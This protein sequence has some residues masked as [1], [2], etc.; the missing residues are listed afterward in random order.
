M[1]PVQD[2][3]I[4]SK[5][6]QTLDIGK[7][8]C[9][10]PPAYEKMIDEYGNLYNEYK[11]LFKHFKK[12]IKLSDL[13]QNELK[14]ARDSQK[15]LNLKLK[16]SNDQL[17]EL[18]SKLEYANIQLSKRQHFIVK[19]INDLSK[20]RFSGDRHAIRNFIQRIFENEKNILI[21]NIS[22]LVYLISQLLIKQKADHELSLFQE[23]CQSFG[24]TPESFSNPKL[25]ENKLHRIVIKNPVELHVADV[26]K[27]EV[28]S[29]FFGKIF[30][31]DI[32]LNDAYLKYKE[33][34]KKYQANEAAEVLWQYDPFS[35]FYALMAIQ[36]IIQE[37]NK[38]FQTYDNIRFFNEVLFSEAVV[39]AK[40]Q[41]IY[42]KKC[43]SDFNFDFEFNPVLTTQEDALI[44]MFRDIF[45]N[46]I[47]AKASMIKLVCKRPTLEIDMPYLHMFNFDI[48]PSLYICVEDN[49]SGIS[50][51][52]AKQLNDYLNGSEYEEH[53]LSTKEKGGLGTKNLREFLRL[54]RGKCHYESVP[55]NTK[56]H[57]FFERLEI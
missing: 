21:G 51:D 14:Q 23:A 41:A 44:Y 37:V 6:E 57:I 50:P 17:T 5:E 49:G 55:Q 54:H 24:L 4:F 52:K 13:L 18:N 35:L 46:S 26:D 32:Y 15:Q 38:R 7:E 31:K 19:L 53:V 30:S 34:Q 40:E 8:I 22:Q 20:I 27:Q 29:K 43:Q 16:E 39:Q 42:E 3:S 33:T 9:L 12:L 28:K 10:N 2:N 47:D 1:N 56:I 36:E 45:Y 11:K 25:I 48:Y